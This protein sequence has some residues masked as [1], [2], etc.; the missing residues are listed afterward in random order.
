ML[1]KRQLIFIAIVCLA[2]LFV[3][4]CGSTT[5]PIPTPTYRL[6]GT[7]TRDQRLED[8]LAELEPGKMLFNPP[9]EMIVGKAEM[10]VLR[11]S[12]DINDTTL[13]T[14]VPGEGEPAIEEVPYLG[15]HM[16]ASLRGEGFEIVPLAEEDQIVPRV[17]YAEWS[18]EVTPTESGV[19][20]LILVA[21]AKVELAKDD[22]EYRSL[23]VIE[24]ETYVNVSITYSFR[25]LLAASWKYLVS[26]AVLG[27]VVFNLSRLVLQQ[28][29]AKRRLQA[30]TPNQ[31]NVNYFDEVHNIVADDYAEGNI[32]SRT[33]IF[34]SAIGGSAIGVMENGSAQLSGRTLAPVVADTS[35]SLALDELHAAAHAT[36]TQNNTTLAEDLDKVASDLEAALHAESA[37]DTTRRNAKLARVQTD[38]QALAQQ[39]PELEALAA[40]VARV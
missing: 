22:V 19:K 8:A 28:M 6:V 18:W 10:I 33:G 21:T 40:L 5:S 31:V 36:R 9:A 24:R 12:R 34:D 35:L 14:N 11:L 13:A 4:G 37:G 7:L 32:D 3:G 25:K 23:P 20:K 29:E 30:E 15:L 39:Q 27:V 17:G 1:S 38:L 26:L 2:F 16:Q